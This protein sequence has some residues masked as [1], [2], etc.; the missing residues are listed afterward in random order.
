MCASV[1]ETGDA[2]SVVP[3]VVAEAGTQAAWDWYDQRAAEEADAADAA[4]KAADA[5]DAAASAADNPT[6]VR[7]QC[8]MLYH[9]VRLYAVVSGSGWHTVIL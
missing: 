3:A 5:A 2:A 1:R 4:K 6:H 7:M 8:C 9:S